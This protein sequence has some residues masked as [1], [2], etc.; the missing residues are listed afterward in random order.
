MKKIQGIENLL[1]YL[2]LAGFPLTEEQVTHLLAD[3][4][5]PH[6]RYGHVTLFYEDHIDWW[7]RQQKR[8]AMKE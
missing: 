5:L 1:C 2:A 8:K 4:K 6:I 7:V 3:K